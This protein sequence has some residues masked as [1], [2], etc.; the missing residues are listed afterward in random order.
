MHITGAIIYKNATQVKKI[1]CLT[2]VIF[3]WKNVYCNFSN[4]SCNIALMYTVYP[5]HY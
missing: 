5:G 3:V 4:K 1:K 2:A